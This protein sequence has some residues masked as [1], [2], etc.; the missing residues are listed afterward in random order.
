MNIWEI[1]L[2]IIIIGFIWMVLIEPYILTI[3]HLKIDN[4][5]LKGLKIV[6]ASDFHIKPYEMFRLKKIVNK[7]N[8]QNPDLILL[9]GDYVNSHNP[10]YT[11]PIE[12]IASELKNLK[13]KNGVIGVLGNHDNWQGKD[14]ILKALADANITILQNENIPL[15]LYKDNTSELKKVFIAGLEDIQT[16]TP[17][18]KKALENTKNPTILLTHSPDTFP[19]VSDNVFLTLAGHTHGG[20]VVIFTPILVPSKYHIKYAYGLKNEGNKKLYITR[21][22]GS[23]ILPIRFNC[24]PEI[25]VIEFK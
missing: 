4:P 5:D 10:K 12:D 20:Q 15:A 9:G 1:I 2:I 17:N 22:L 21:G 3:K 25:V 24:P 19:E 13:A 7:I 6:F 11:C 14:K 8:E 16:Q 23:S 18:I